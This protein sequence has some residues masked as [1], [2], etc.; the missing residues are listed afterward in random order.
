MFTYDVVVMTQSDFDGSYGVDTYRVSRAKALDW[1]KSDR[2]L[3]LQI[4]VA[5]DNIPNEE[6]SYREIPYDEIAF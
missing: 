6:I 4:N 1:M 3:D 5:H 2:F